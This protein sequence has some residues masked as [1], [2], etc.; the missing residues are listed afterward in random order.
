MPH[1]LTQLVLGD[2]TR[3]LLDKIRQRAVS[4]P[5]CGS[6]QSASEIDSNRMCE[7]PIL[8]RS[9]QTA[10]QSLAR[11]LGGLREQKANTIAQ[12]RPHPRPGAQALKPNTP[13]HLRSDQA[14]TT[15]L[16]AMPGIRPSEFNPEI[17]DIICSAIVN[18]QALTKLCQEDKRLPNWTTIFKWRRSNPDFDH[19]YAQAREM[20]AELWADEIIEIADEPAKDMAAVTR[21][22]LRVDT[23]KWLLSKLLPKVYGDK[24]EVHGDLTLS[25]LVEAAQSLRA[26]GDEA[27]LI[28]PTPDS[29]SGDRALQAPDK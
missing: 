2:A 4:A 27:K 23:R 25:A 7:A 5:S 6:K 13:K 11:T 19:A 12:G 17:A 16:P 20:R 29:A 14:S 9:V 15:S 21:A 10:P 18:G 8:A 22:R 24:L 3:I 1:C 26:N 28:G